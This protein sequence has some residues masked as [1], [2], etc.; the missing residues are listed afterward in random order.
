MKQKLALIALLLSA[1]LLAGCLS[2]GDGSPG[3][4]I[5]VR[6]VDG[7][8]PMPNVEVLYS[9]PQ[10]KGG[11]AGFTDSRG[12]VTITS[13]KGKVDVLFALD[14]YDAPVHLLTTDH[15]GV[16]AI[17]GVPRTP[18]IYIDWY[19]TAPDGYDVMQVD[20]YCQDPQYNTY[21]AVFNWDKGYAGFQQRHDGRKLLMSL[22]DLDDGTQPDVEYAPYGL[23]GSFDHEGSGSFAFTDYEW[24]EETW[25][26]MRI[27]RWEEDG[28]TYYE[29]WVR[30]EGGEWL[31][32]AVI[33]Y[34]AEGPRFR[35]NGMF[36]EDWEG[37]NLGRSCRLRNMY[38]RNLK[39]KTWES[40]NKYYV[41]TMYIPVIE[42]LS[43][44]PG[45]VWE[46]VFWDI[47]YGVDWD[48]G[49]NGEYVWIRNGGGDFNGNGKEIPV[50]YTVNQPPQPGD[51][52]WLE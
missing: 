19:G 10:I 28:K 40:W 32:T 17:S 5:T 26:S 22:W 35:S 30:E 44:I 46:Y 36:Q 41:T 34:P 7:E 20:W 25:Y 11:S 14:G 33:S 15:P 37:N 42:H 4:E 16:Y 6:L 2:V 31:K 12:E 3:Y 51:T 49:P 9:G 13:L 38:A 45:S 48:L 1:A 8:T 39:T 21:W 23:Y 24:K 29:Q 50:V 43:T 27:Q 52:R 18:G 47:D